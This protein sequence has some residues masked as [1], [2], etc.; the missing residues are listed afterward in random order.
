MAIQVYLTGNS[1]Y[2]GMLVLTLDPRG[3]SPGTLVFPSCQ[4]PMFPNS[5]FMADLNP[6]GGQKEPHLDV[7]QYVSHVADNVVK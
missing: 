2:V 1:Y 6:S 3:F 4:K 7:P 5:S